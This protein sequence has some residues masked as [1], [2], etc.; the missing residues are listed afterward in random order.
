MQRSRLDD[1]FSPEELASMDPRNWT[2]ED[3]LRFLEDVPLSLEVFLER[4]PQDRNTF[5]AALLD[6]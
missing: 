1:L 4:A 2:P 3:E 5:P 6:L